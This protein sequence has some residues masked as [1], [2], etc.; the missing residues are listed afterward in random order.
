M[1]DTFPT[2]PCKQKAAVPLTQEVAVKEG[3]TS[4]PELDTQQ[5]D[6]PTGGQLIQQ[7]PDIVCVTAPC[8]GFPEPNPEPKPPPQCIP[9][10]Y[11]APPP[12][13]AASP[14]RSSLL[15]DLIRRLTGGGGPRGITGDIRG[16]QGSVEECR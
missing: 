15:Q 5:V 13:P 11:V 10:P 4:L 1:H 16:K 14:T 3:P 12:R 2:S 9:R 6:R 7:P 8:P